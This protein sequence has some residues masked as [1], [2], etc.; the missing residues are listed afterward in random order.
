MRPFFTV[1]AVISAACSALGQQIAGAHTDIRPCFCGNVPLSRRCPLS[2][3]L[4][5]PGRFRAVAVWVVCVC[6][7]VYVCAFT[8]VW[9]RIMCELGAYTYVCVGVVSSASHLCSESRTDVVFVVV[10][11]RRVRLPANS[12]DDD[13]S[14]CLSNCNCCINGR[15]RPIDDCKKVGKIIG[16]VVGAIVFM[17]IL[18]V[19]VYCCRRRHRL[20]HYHHHHHH[21][22][23]DDATFYGKAVPVSP[24]GTYA[25]PG[26]QPGAYSGQ[27]QPGVAVAV[28]PPGMYG[29]PQGQPGAYGAPQGQPGAYAVPPGQPGA[30]GAPQGQP[31]VYAPYGV[32][33]MQPQQQPYAPGQQPVYY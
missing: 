33:P 10:R 4:S 24:P 9:T 14:L 27:Q 19:V 15:C 25:A 22:C 2:S 6:V 1:L 12:H 30:Y 5:F 16:G 21:E 29:A 8:L 28:P 17:V 31:G 20:R 7:F 11:P 26:G 23:E 32:A 18:C 13:D 3:T